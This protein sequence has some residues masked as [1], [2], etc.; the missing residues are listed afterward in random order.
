MVGKL[1]E[2]GLQTSTLIH[3]KYFSTPYSKYR[4]IET[5]VGQQVHERNILS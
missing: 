2:E 3:S 5:A 4:L 1:E